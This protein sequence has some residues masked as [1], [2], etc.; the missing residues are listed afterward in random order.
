MLDYQGSSGPIDASNVQLVAHSVSP[1]LVSGSHLGRTDQDGPKLRINER[2]KQGTINRPCFAV[3]H[4]N[5]SCCIHTH[6]TMPLP[7]ETNAMISAPQGDEDATQLAVMLDAKPYLAND[8]YLCRL[9][10]SSAIKLYEITSEPDGDKR[11]A[12]WK[13]FAN[14]GDN[15]FVVQ[16]FFCEYVSAGLERWPHA[17]I[18]QLTSGFQHPPQRRQL[19]RRQL[20]LCRRLLK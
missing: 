5:F 12:L 18:I 9:R 4:A 20:H 15:C 2:S 10:N 19:Y 17:S 14:V 11:M 8:K 1:S 7:H 6:P 13:Q 16:R 3:S